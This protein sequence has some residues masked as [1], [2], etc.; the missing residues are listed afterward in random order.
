MLHA[1]EPA[2]EGARRF[3]TSHYQQIKRLNPKLPF[4]VRHS[5]ADEPRFIV[6]YGLFTDPFLS[7]T[8]KRLR[9]G[10]SS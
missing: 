2:S 9:W 3:L 4:L 8:R 5:Y 1:E 6:R 10:G 7:L